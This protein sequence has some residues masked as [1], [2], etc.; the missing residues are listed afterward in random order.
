MLHFMNFLYY[1]DLTVLCTT[2][3]FY[4]SEYLAVDIIVQFYGL[5]I[6]CYEIIMRITIEIV[7]YNKNFMLDNLHVI[8]SGS[9]ILGVFANVLYFIR[10]P[11]ELLTMLR[12]IYGLSFFVIYLLNEYVSL[13]QTPEESINLI[14]SKRITQSASTIGASIYMVIIQFIPV[15]KINL[16]IRPSNISGILFVVI[17]L[18]YFIWLMYKVCRSEDKSNYFKEFIHSIDTE[19]KTHLVKNLS[20]SRDTILSGFTI[21]YMTAFSLNVATKFSLN[22]ILAPLSSVIFR[23]QMKEVC[24]IFLGLS[25][26]NFLMYIALNIKRRVMSNKIRLI[27]MDIMV[28]FGI[29]I[30]VIAVA[31]KS[32]KVFDQTVGLT[33]F[34]FGYFLANIAQTG[35]YLLL[36]NLLVG[37]S[38]SLEQVLLKK[39]RRSFKFFGSIFGIL[40][41][42]VFIVW[43]SFSLGILTLS[44]IVITV[45]TIL[46]HEVES[47]KSYK[48]TVKR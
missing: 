31:A 32:Y 22:L 5:V 15:N 45:F 42:P 10:P 35:S 28:I 21:F 40:N 48:V 20:M 11:V 7:L 9:S 24:F 13:N 46:F 27:L 3:W 44:W 1:F 37:E 2:F 43:P 6:L 16:T 26:M 41:G 47:K 34:L 14:I 30:I 29:M 18:T 8:L 23:L 39:M 38:T 19:E 12:V 25:L 33:L 4:L 17:W 36:Q